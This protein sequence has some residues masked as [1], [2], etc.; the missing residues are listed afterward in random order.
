VRKMSSKISFTIEAD[1]LNALGQLVPGEKSPLSIFNVKDGKKPADKTQRLQATGLLDPSGKIRSEYSLVLDTLAK[2]MNVSSLKYTAGSKLF[3]FIV[4]FPNVKG[5]PSIS[6]LHDGNQVIIQS[7][8]GVE[9]AFTLIDQNVG[10]SKLS[11]SGFSG[12]FSPEEAMALL[13]L[14]DLERAANLHAIADGAAVKSTTFDLA[15]IVDKVAKCAKTLQ[16]LEYALQAQL[17]L[18]TQPTADPVGA[19][20]K[21]LVDK[22]LVSLQNGNYQLSDVASHFAGR[23]PIIDNFV[24]VEAGKFDGDGKLIYANFTALQAGVNDILYFENHDKE[25]VIKSVSGMELLG[26]VAK[27][28]N[29]PDAI[30]LPIPTAAPTQPASG[31]SKKFCRQC[32]APL[33]P[34]SKY[35]E[36]C[37]NKTLP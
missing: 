6:A 26:L 23:L 37:G 24:S 3:E 10:H 4:T 9:D 2:A 32:G 16:S 30:K 14:M 12:K 22:K 35:C 5:T 8:A 31:A 20:L 34:N 18:S 33:P 36:T 25:I 17:E 29:E 21:G 28:L 13:A 1:L 15:A 19:G 27:Y 11:S 7:P